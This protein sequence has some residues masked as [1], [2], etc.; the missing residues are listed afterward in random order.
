MMVT[1]I[2]VKA[3]VAGSMDELGR[4]SRGV[5]VMLLYWIELGVREREG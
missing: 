2:K 1:W 4:Y 5:T 3:F